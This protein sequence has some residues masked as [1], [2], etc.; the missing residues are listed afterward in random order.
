VIGKLEGKT[1]LG[2]SRRS[3]KDV[4]EIELENFEWIHLA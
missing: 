4:R 3:W 1:P 2:R